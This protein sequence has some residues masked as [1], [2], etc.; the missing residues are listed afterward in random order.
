MKPKGSLRRSIKF[1]ITLAK[2]M[3]KKKMALIIASEM[4]EVTSR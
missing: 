3:R 4:R 2:L 1:I